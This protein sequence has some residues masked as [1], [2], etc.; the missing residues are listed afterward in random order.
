MKNIYFIIAALLFLLMLTL[1]LFSLGSAEREDTKKP[2]LS[3][4]TTEKKPNTVI[5]LNTENGNTQEMTVTDYIFGVVAAEMPMSYEDEAI[6]AQA[7]AAHTFLLYRKAENADK[8]YDITSD[9]SID[10]AFL[11]K[12]ELTKKWGEKTE[13]HTRRLSAIL[14]EVDGMYI[15]YESKPILAVYHAISSGKTESCKNVWGKSLNYLTSVESIGDILSADYLSTVKISA[16]D[17]KKAFKNKCTL[18]SKSEN[19]IEKISRSKSGTVTS[20][21]IGGK[22][23]KGSDVRAAFSLRSS[24]FDVE[25]QENNFVF[26]VRGYGHGVGMSQYGANYMAQQGNTFSEILCWYYKG[27]EIRKF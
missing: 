19:Y 9:F 22:T 7:V 20:I 14:N 3:S 24:N 2:T 6:K 27:C 15:S 17:F 1:P 18:P 10:Q 8:N 23:F 16:D 5:V 26:T 25:L 11:S 21:V 4:T 13:E 12:D